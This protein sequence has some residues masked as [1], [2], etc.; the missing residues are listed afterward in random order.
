MNEKLTKKGDHHIIQNNFYLISRYF[1]L[2]LQNAISESI[3]KTSLRGNGRYNE[4]KSIGKENNQ[5][6]KNQKKET[7]NRVWKQ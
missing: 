4:T 2:F 1:P 3:Y 5:P 7:N 6:T